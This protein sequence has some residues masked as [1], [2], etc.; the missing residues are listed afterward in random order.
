MVQV[1]FALSRKMNSVPSAPVCIVLTL[2]FGPPRVEIT[3]LLGSL[4]VEFTLLLSAFC[5]N[6][7]LCFGHL[8]FP[9]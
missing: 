9:P 4:C 5:I 7:A 1:S 6:P 8:S 2:I 3:I